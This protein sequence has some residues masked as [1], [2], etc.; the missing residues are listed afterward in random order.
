MQ[1]DPLGGHW[2]TLSIQSFMDALRRHLKDETMIAWI[3]DDLTVVWP[4]SELHAAATFIKQQ[5]CHY[6]LKLKAAKCKL[7]S[8]ADPSLDLAS[9][10]FEHSTQG[11]TKL[12]GAPVG[13]V[14]HNRAAATDRVKQ[15]MKD[16]AELHRLQDSQIEYQLLKYCLCTRV[17]HLTRMLPPSMLTEALTAYEAQ[18]KGELERLV[19]TPDMPAFNFEIAKQPVRGIGI[20]LQDLPLVAEAAYI[21]SQGNTARLA[22][23][24][25]ANN[26][27]FRKVLEH[28][29]ADTTLREQMA[30]LAEQVNS[31]TTPTLC[32]T[33]TSIEATPSQH[34]L[35]VPLYKAKEKMLIAQARNVKQKARLLSQAGQNSGAFLQAQKGV[36][37]FFNFSSSTYRNALQWRLHLPLEAT[38]HMAKCPCNDHTL[39][40][41]ELLDGWHF[42]TRCQQTNRTSRHDGIRDVIVALYKELRQTVGTEPN[43]LHNFGN[44]RPAD[45]LAFASVHNTA[46]HLALDVAVISP[47]NVDKLPAAATQQYHAAKGKEKAKIKQYE[48]YLGRLNPPETPASSDYE[49]VPLVM[50]S[51]GAW[52]PRMQSWWKDV[53]KLYNDVEADSGNSRR[54]KGL[55]HTW[56]ANSFTSWWAQRISCTYVRHLIENIE[57]VAKSGAYSHYHA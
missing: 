47:D 39:T 42:A 51:T 52:G 23:K 20:G 12:L 34:R 31:D 26:P 48:N 56:S 41:D 46:K 50:E 27:A 25:K 37:K 16:T 33:L 21:A 18:V 49:K 7:Y 55:A 35:A 45:V 5:G 24:V 38:K 11:I 3:V 13:R 36:H 10:A 14:A 57:R 28:Q 15:K 1:G 43:R 4:H 29:Q 44:D 22:S 53:I 19:R 30:N 9:H 54:Q 32:P 6:G 17:S 2:F 8:H 40:L